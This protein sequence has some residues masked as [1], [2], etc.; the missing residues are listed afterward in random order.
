MSKKYT[1]IILPSR[2]Q[3]DTIVSIFL[4]KTFGKEKYPGIEH[5]TVEIMSMLPENEDTKSFDKNGVLLIDIGKGKFDHH[6]TNK[7]ASEIIANDL[8]IQDK[9]SLKM[10]LQYVERDDKHGMGTVSKDPIDRAFGLSGLTSTLNKTLQENPQKVIDIV[11]PLLHS[12]YEE[13]KK[14]IEELPKE[15]EEKLNQEK[16]KSTYIKHKGKKIKV[17]SIESDNRSMAGYLRSASGEK[18]DVVIQKMNSGHVNIVTLQYKKIDLRISAGLLRN[19]EGAM[20]NKKLKLT[21]KELLVSGR[22]DEIPEWYYDTATNSIL[23]GGLHT[24]GTNPTAIPF[25]K[26]INIIL[27]GL[28]D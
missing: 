26:L 28:K 17:I 21:P 4:L 24:T 18:A 16:I 6:K 14:R 20:R 23:N 1:K 25:D 9:P 19:E 2:P 10:L 8:G 7:T 3:I 15:F 11:L 27:E 22:I 12:H 5:A 13:Q